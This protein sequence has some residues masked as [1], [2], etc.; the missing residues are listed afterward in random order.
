VIRPG[1]LA[2]ALLLAGAA[3]A[4]EA[5][6]LFARRTLLG[7]MAGLRPWLAE[8]GVEFS[9][10]YTPEWFWNLRGGLDA[11][12]AR[13]HRWAASL[14]V[15]A[16]PEALGLWRRG[17][18]FAHAQGQY[19]KTLSGGATGDWQALSN[20][21]GDD[22]LQVS[23]LWYRHSFLGDRLWI[24][25]GKQDLNN[26]FAFVE[27]GLEF[28]HSS[29]GL[30]PT[31]PLPT[32]PDPDLA[33]TAGINP[34]PWFSLTVAPAQGRS[35]AAAAR[36]LA[37]P[38][39]LCQPALNHHLLG[40]EG[41]LCLGAWWNGADL[42]RLDRTAPD[43]GRAGSSFGFYATLDQQ[44]WLEDPAAGDDQ[45]LGL[46]VQFGRAPADRSEARQ[47]TGIGLRWAGALPGRDED[48]AGL[49]LF[50]VQFS[51]ELGLPRRAEAAL[52]FFYRLRLLG[53][54]AA[55]PDLQAIF[56]PGGTNARTA[57]AL[58]FR[59]EIEF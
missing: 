53:W 39:L 15:E 1:V 8:R 25:A 56:H 50:R 58:G 29:A 20:L 48:I 9:L 54:L 22:F 10:V 35:A 59:L 45:G 21:E 49:G 6:G 4:Q 18:F 26:D 32:A 14:F 2:A 55:T 3:A 17:T 34:V 28:L 7:S 37:G 42:E 23:E 52:E 12:S 38:L 40:G 46:F 16:A 19:G 41:T 13:A 47:Y 44:L 36:D 30:I 11:A 57:L 31:L 43:P 51:P 24:K 27:N 33:L 5:E